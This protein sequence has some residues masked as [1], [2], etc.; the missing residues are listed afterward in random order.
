MNRLLL[1]AFALL[2]LFSLPVKSHAA[3]TTPD[4]SPVA[5]LAG[6]DGVVSMHASNAVVHGT[7]LRYEPA[8]NKLC[9]G[10]WTKAEDWAEWKFTVTKPGDYVV[11]IW[12]GCGTG[13]G[14]SDVIAEV[15]GKSFPFVV[16]D[17]GH[18]QK[19]IPRRVGTLALTAGTHT[20][21]VKPQNK[22]KAA[23]M[24]I[25]FVKIIPADKA[26]ESAPSATK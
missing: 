20:I 13:N 2:L 7:M 11:E 10:F 3:D 8:T 14:G 22:K 16:E 18:F 26:N 4:R 15:A 12:Q 6:A 19:F 17:T 23:V 9:L 25:R 1:N 21:A 5:V 24:D